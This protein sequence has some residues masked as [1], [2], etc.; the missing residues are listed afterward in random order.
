LATVVPN[1]TTIES[2]F[3]MVKW[4]KNDTRTSL[5]NLALVG[6]M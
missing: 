1:T 4:E 2:D 6:I 3:S 5:T